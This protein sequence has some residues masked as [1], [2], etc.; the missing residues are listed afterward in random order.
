[1]IHSYSKIRT[2]YN[3]DFKTHLTI[4][5]LQYLPA[6]LFWD[7]IKASLTD[8]KGIPDIA[9]EIVQIDFWIKWYTTKKE[10]VEPDV[11]IRF[12]NFDCI[13]EAKKKDINGQ[14]NEQWENQKKAYENKYKEKRLV[15]IALGGNSNFSTSSDNVYKSTWQRLLHETYKALKERESFEYKTDAIEQEI[16]IL[17]SVVDAFALYNEYVIELLDTMKKYNYTVI[18]PTKELWDQLW[19]QLWKKI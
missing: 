8:N 9:G 12:K 16:R 4:G 10:Y 19:D 17:K 3:E 13:I 1:M 11:F 14:Y 7:I 15:Y 5:V 18:Q 6:K 2:D